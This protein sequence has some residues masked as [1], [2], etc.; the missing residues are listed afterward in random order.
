MKKISAVV[1]TY[2][3]ENKIDRALNSLLDLCD[4]IIVVDSF[5]TDS[6]LERCRHYTDRIEQR[7]WPGYRDQKQYATDQAKYE[8]VLSLD[9]D[10]EVGAGLRREI[11]HW[12]Q[13]SEGVEYN[14]YYVARKAFFLGC[15][16]NHTTWYP[17]WQLRLF[18]K[19]R[20]KWEGGRVHEAFKVASPTSKFHGNLYHYTYSSIDEYLGQLRRFSALA[21]ADNLDRGKRAGLSDLMLRPPIAFFSNYFLHRGFLDGTAGFIVS[22]LA[23]VST[24]FKY[25]RLWQIQ[26]RDRQT[27]FGAS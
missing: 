18:Q 12:K 6:T 9:A 13:S 23:A 16:I 17:D 25:L 11:Q 8:W 7:A 4:E 20:G 15:F 24:F 21:A 26:S 2:N 19:E 27:P 14:G 22:V 5:S 1:I 10:E 3:E